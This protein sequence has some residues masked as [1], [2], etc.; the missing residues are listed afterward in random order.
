MGKKDKKAEK[1]RLKADETPEERHARRLAKKRKKHGEDAEYMGYQNQENRFGDA[2]L[3]EQFTWRKKIDKMVAGGEDPRNV[4]K[5]AQ[6]E[7]SKRVKTE[8]EQLK[9][10]REERE[11]EKE[12]M[13]EERERLSREREAMNYQE[14]ERKEEEFHRQQGR[15]RTEIRVK[16]G[17]ARPIDV[18]A[19]N[20]LLDKHFDMEMHEPYKV[21][22][23]LVVKELIGLREEMQ[24]Q[25]AGEAAEYWDALLVCCGDELDAKQ[26]GGSNTSASGG[27]DHGVH[28]SVRKDLDMMLQGKSRGELDELQ[29]QINGH[30]Q[31]GG[32]GDVEYW[33]SL[34]K[35]LKVHNAKATLRDFHQ[36]LMRRRL[37]KMAAADGGVF[38]EDG[39]ARAPAGMGYEAMTRKNPLEEEAAPAEDPAA[40]IM[41]DYSA[42]V[43][44][45]PESGGWSPLYT[46][47]VPEEDDEIVVTEEEDLAEITQ[48]R[49]AILQQEAAH[50]SAAI[51]AA[52]THSKI[53]PTE[54]ALY[55]AT[56]KASEGDQTTVAFKE[57]FALEKNSYTWDDKY[58]P[59]KPRYFNRVHTGYE[60][61]KYNQTHYDHDN[62]PPKVVQGYKF[63]V[64]YPDLIDKTKAPQFFIT[65]DPDGN[66]E[67]SVLRIS[68]G[69]PYED[70]AFKILNR[71]W[72]YSHKH[73]YKCSFERGIFHLCFNFKKHRY[74]R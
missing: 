74:R 63:N 31:S 9:I 24:V 34:L 45:E 32:G 35:R 26:D 6:R 70:I 13:E 14:W 15:R 36:D 49:Q 33:E 67:V 66:K 28:Q 73:G 5:Q 21:F 12:M 19:K 39:E 44:E 17:R 3:Q 43:V 2:N 1:E 50:V 58:Q 65:R 56:A 20:L 54:D 69:P 51:L 23:G 30:I 22:R 59:R 11:K 62:P 10:Q 55:R 72:E 42:A 29:G 8:I 64:F 7:R 16:N 47:T 41:P 57:E 53:G 25:A 27:V 48:M 60:W 71:E 40:A 61:N 18:L 46:A 37:K 4:S 52:P 38:D 68:A